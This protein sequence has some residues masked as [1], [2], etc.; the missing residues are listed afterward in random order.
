MLAGLVSWCA[1]LT[2]KGCSQL[3]RKE[4]SHTSDIKI[5]LLP[6]SLT[7]FGFAPHIW[8][9]LCA[10]LHIFR[11]LSFWPV[12]WFADLGAP[13][14]FP[15]VGNA[16][17]RS[18][19]SMV[20]ES[21]PF[22]SFFVALIRLSL[23]GGKHEARFDLALKLHDAFWGYWSWSFSRW[24]MQFQT[25]LGES[26]AIS[27]VSARQQLQGVQLDPL[28]D[29]GLCFNLSSPDY[30]HRWGCQPALL[31]QLLVSDVSEHICH[32]R[33]WLFKKNVHV[34][35]VLGWSHD[36]RRHRLFTYTNWMTPIWTQAL[37]IIASSNSR[38]FVSGRMEAAIP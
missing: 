18:S 4:S 22:F 15:Y 35:Q 8:T 20:L 32:Q 1:R 36:I 30:L 34:W 21:E 3:F 6:F 2:C 10:F 14:L 16:S 28:S 24:S 19:G 37:F 31:N 5:Q 7:T 29:A 9:A 12:F 13:F 17:I 11:S 26:N 23:V 27:W 33:F 25:V 38:Q